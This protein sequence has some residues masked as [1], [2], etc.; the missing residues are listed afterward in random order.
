MPTVGINGSLAITAVIT[1][2]TAGTIR[3]YR[4]LESPAAWHETR[5]IGKAAG[6]AAAGSVDGPFGTIAATILG[7]RQP[8]RGGGAV[9]W[10]STTGPQTAA[11]C[12]Q[13]GLAEPRWWRARADRG[14]SIAFV[15]RR[16]GR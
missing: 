9:A 16:A 15:A 2:R 3:R 4:D 14:S 8:R 1:T 10:T 13:C 12:R 6:M 11:S 7:A 5:R